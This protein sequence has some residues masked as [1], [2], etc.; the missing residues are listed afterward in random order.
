ML[1]RVF[2]RKMEFSNA[3]ANTVLTRDIPHTEIM[4]RMSSDAEKRRMCSRMQSGR[5]KRLG[6]CVMLLLLLVISGVALTFG[7][8]WCCPSFW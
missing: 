5:R 1:E 7:N 3:S 6:V 2:S 8:L 4:L